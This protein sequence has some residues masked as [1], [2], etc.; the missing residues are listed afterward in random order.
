M[1]K[2]N[3]PLS[4]LQSANSIPPIEVVEGTYKN[5]Q[6]QAAYNQKINVKP[7][8]TETPSISLDDKI[9][10]F[11][12]L[13][14]AVSNTFNIDEDFT[15]TY[16]KYQE[17]S[18]A[19]IDWDRVH[20]AKQDEASTNVVR[21]KAAYA[22]LSNEFSKYSNFDLQK[23]SLK[24]DKSVVGGFKQDFHDRLS[25]MYDAA[26]DDIKKGIRINSGFRDS[27]YQKRIID[28][29]KGRKGYTASYEGG[30]RRKSDN[31]QMVAS[32][33]GS[34]HGQGV[35]ADLGYGSKN[36]PARR[37][38]HNNAKNFGLHFPLSYEPWHIEPISA[39]K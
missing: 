13:N 4:L 6:A 19:P 12:H 18:T 24:K 8:L 7:L 5:K 30:V 20:A 23:I 17:S 36:T 15:Q 22:D 35:A 2:K 3:N 10:M 9:K 27:N 38:V 11:N 29:Y 14:A 21:A 16:L 31:K 1:P 34:K 25:A 33:H 26:P 39:R 28:K 37:W 32:A